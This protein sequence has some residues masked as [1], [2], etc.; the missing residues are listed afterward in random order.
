M[1]KTD[2][3]NILSFRGPARGLQA[4]LSVADTSPSIAAAAVLE[5]RKGTPKELKA[6]AH[7]Q[8]SARVL[9]PGVV[10]VKLKFDRQAPPGTY[11]GR[12]RLG[13]QEYEFEAEVK[14]VPQLSAAPA[15]LS[16]EGVSDGETLAEITLANAG[17]AP[18]DVRPAYMVGLFQ[19]GGVEEALGKAYREQGIDGRPWIDRVGGHLAEAHGGLAR[20]KVVEGAGPLMPGEARRIQ[21]HIRFPGNLRP[22]RSY[23]GKI[24]FDGLVYLV[25]VDVPK[26][27]P[28]KI[29]EEELR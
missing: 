11:H 10:R 13:E 28:D 1:A 17:N 27:G 4:I 6:V 8:V 2:A 9:A 3:S 26:S 15:S 19:L 29:A 24:E 18:S 12:V 14:P 16:L 25:R 5:P 23:D 21:L 22:G 7:P 20:V